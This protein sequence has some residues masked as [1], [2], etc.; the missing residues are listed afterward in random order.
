M[1]IDPNGSPPPPPSVPSW[2]INPGAAPSPSKLSQLAE[3]LKLEHQ[4]VRVPFDHYKKKIRFNHRIVGKELSV[5]ISAVQE[6]GAV[7]V[8][9]DEAVKRLTSV[10]SRLQGLKR[11]LE[12][13]SLTEQLQAQ[14]CR[15]RLDH[16]ESVDP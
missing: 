1:E 11:K 8:S 2:T 14:R 6:T 3:S 12:E 5:V 15:T 16:L 10:V 4:L 7:G 13:G 9:G